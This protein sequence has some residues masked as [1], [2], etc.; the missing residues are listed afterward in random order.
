MAGRSRQ[1]SA[2]KHKHLRLDR[3]RDAN[4]TISRSS[5]RLVK[6]SATSDHVA[7]QL[8]LRSKSI[9]TNGPRTYPYVLHTRSHLC[10]EPIHTHSR[11]H[12]LYV[13]N[14]QSRVCRQNKQR[15]KASR[16]QKTR[17]F[18][19]ILDGQ[20][21]VEARPTDRNGFVHSGCRCIHVFL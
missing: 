3:N 11:I 21:N 4:D 18:T 13:Q 16:A 9:N 2:S 10:E 8:D 20:H 1:L 15:Q 5:A 19:N 12:L 6:L 17:C 14:A 7:R